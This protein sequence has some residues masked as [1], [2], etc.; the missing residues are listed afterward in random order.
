MLV[1]G[2]FPRVPATFQ[3]FLDEPFFIPAR[4]SQ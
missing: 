1:A 3:A 2:S 4:Q